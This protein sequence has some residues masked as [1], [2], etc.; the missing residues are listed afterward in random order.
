[1]DSISTP[2]A[3]LSRF[4]ILPIALIVALG[5]L[6]LPAVAQQEVDSMVNRMMARWNEDLKLTKDQ[7]NRMRVI[8]QD[9]I[10]QTRALWKKYEGLTSETKDRLNDFAV[11]RKAMEDGIDKRLAD[12][13]S[14][15]QLEN[16]KKLRAERRRALR[17]RGRADD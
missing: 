9:Q 3:R 2:S 17:S 10:N 13:L 5:L 7:S 4:R 1:M 15:E 14:A 11:E 8:L 16:Y 12:V 6:A